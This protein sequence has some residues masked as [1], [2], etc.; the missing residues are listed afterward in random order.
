MNNKKY[1]L[2]LSMFFLLLIT[3]SSVSALGVMPASKTMLIGEKTSYPMKIINTNE[4]D[5]TA[6]VIVQ[7]SLADYITVSKE[8]IVFTKDKENEIISVTVDV[9]D[10]ILLEEYEYENSVTIITASGANG[11]ITGSVN[12]VSGLTLVNPYMDAHLPEFGTIAAGVTLVGAF[13]IFL[14]TRRNQ[15]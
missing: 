13:G 7:G 15:E 6:H 14:F 1:V 9:P 5:F 11:Q 2:G 8:I 4:A 3:L 12:V 10:D